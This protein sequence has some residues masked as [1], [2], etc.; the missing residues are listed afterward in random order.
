MAKT[1]QIVKTCS[2]TFENLNENGRLRIVGLNLGM[3]I[4]GWLWEKTGTS[5]TSAKANYG[6]NRLEASMFS[7][8]LS[9]AFSL[10]SHF[11]VKL[12]NSNII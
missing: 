5:N 3:D 8:F 11:L 10:K 4:Q 2:V 12:L 9:K 7:Y 6:Q 1:I